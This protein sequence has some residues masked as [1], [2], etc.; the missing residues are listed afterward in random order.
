MV[1]R[2]STGG[3]RELGH[4]QARLPELERVTPNQHVRWSGD[5]APSPGGRCCRPRAR[6]HRLQRICPVR[7]A[8]PRTHDAALPEY[9]RA[10][11]PVSPCHDLTV[12]ALFG[13]KKALMQGFHMGG[14]GL[15]PVTPSLSIRGNRSH[16]F[17]PVRSMAQKGDFATSNRTRPH[18][19]ERRTLPLLPRS[20]L[21]KRPR[22][23]A[24]L[25]RPDRSARGHSNS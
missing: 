25:P 6:R 8:S 20:A 3:I 14:T 13:N 19:S 7:G 23:S 10:R 1:R 4:R 12:V 11:L 16:L 18:P 17:A 21:R 5:L 2:G 22:A 9:D 24:R 15:E